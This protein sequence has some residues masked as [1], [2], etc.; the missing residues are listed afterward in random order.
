MP[1]GEVRL[2]LSSP[3]TTRSTFSKSGISMTADIVRIDAPYRNVEHAI[4]SAYRIEAH[5]IVNVSRFLQDLRGG[6]VRMPSQG[7]NQYE[8]HA[9]AAMV[10]AFAKRSLPESL[11]L[12][13]ECYFTIPVADLFDRKE[14]QAEH[15]GREVWIELDVRT[16][17][18]WYIID[19]TR[20]WAGVP[21]H[22]SEEWWS[23]HLDKSV[24]ALRYWRQ[25]KNGKPGMEQLLN[26][27]LNTGLERLAGPMLEAGIVQYG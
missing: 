9:Q 1:N 17:D 10:M 2:S 8:Q 23:D 20:V 24:R 13:L 6:T 4:R 5:D 3:Q 25:G 15:I 26:D 16:A 11:Y 12:A 14:R 7:L 27:R 19:R 18:K 22:H 21:N